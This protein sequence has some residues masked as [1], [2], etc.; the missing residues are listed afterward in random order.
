MSADRAQTGQRVAEQLDRLIILRRVTESITS[1][2]GSELTGRAMDNWAHQAGV[3][4]S[5]LQ[6]R[7]RLAQLGPLE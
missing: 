7:T 5:C 1:Y 6:L 3:K 4:R 2:N